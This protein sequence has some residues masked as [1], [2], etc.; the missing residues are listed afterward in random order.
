MGAGVFVVMVTWKRGREIL[1]EKLRSQAIP[2]EPF[3]KSVV[4]DGITR[5]PRTAVFLMA[6]PE[7]VPR[8]LLHNLM[9]NN[10]LHER[11]VFLTVVYE[12]V[13]YVP[14]PGRVLIET[15]GNEFYRVRIFYGF[16]RRNAPC[17]RSI[18]ARCPGQS[19][20]DGGERSGLRER[21]LVGT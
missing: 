16:M 12:N 7:G 18:S 2:L 5:V 1:V 9:H 21:P 4:D 15:L 20:G 10:V 19:N 6:S 14:L 13:P 8:A 11:V 17:G 3:L